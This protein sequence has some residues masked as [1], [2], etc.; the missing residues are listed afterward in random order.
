MFHKGSFISKKKSAFSYKTD[1][2][3]K[4]Y[5]KYILPAVRKD[6]QLNYL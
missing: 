6:K 1:L 5:K 4:S 3:A 2:S